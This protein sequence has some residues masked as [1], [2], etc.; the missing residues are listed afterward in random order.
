[1]STGVQ[2]KRIAGAAEGGIH[3]LAEGGERGSIQAVPP[4]GV[5]TRKATRW[6]RLT[7]VSLLRLV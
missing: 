5:S 4:Y 2:S 1:M 3:P 6:S 7:S